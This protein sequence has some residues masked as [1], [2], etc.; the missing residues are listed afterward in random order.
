MYKQYLAEAEK[1]THPDFTLAYLVNYTDQLLATYQ[2]ELIHLRD[3][4]DNRLNTEANC[5]LVKKQLSIRGVRPET[6]SSTLLNAKNIP[7]KLEELCDLASAIHKDEVQL[8]MNIREMGVL[9]KRLILF[10]DRL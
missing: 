8:T 9:T 7:E 3:F 1:R 5:I 6:V 4:R 10:K 2:E